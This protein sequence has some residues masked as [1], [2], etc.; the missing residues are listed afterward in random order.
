MT[1]TEKII[2]GKLLEGHRINGSSPG[3]IRL[4]DPAGHPVMKISDAFFY[5]IRPV[6]RKKKLLFL[7]DL[8]KVRSMHGNSFIKKLYRGKVKVPDGKISA[9]HARKKAK[10]AV[11]SSNTLLIFQ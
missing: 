2:A 4:V 9:P 7:I 1:D 5:E 6:L 11:I 8:R 10:T 3:C